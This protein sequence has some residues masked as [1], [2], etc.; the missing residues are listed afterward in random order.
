MLLYRKAVCRKCRGGPGITGL[1]D[2]VLL[3]YER[4]TDQ[5]DA[6]QKRRA[7]YGQGYYEKYAGSNVS[8]SDGMINADCCPFLARVM[9]KDLIIRKGNG[10]DT[11]WAGKYVPPGAY[12]IVEVKAGKG[13][14]AGWGRLKSGA[15]WIVLSYAAKRV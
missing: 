11:A 10:T 4:P 8:S 7:G 2:A 5:S 6:V 14:N 13:S 15:G 1:G 9:A 3:W 12:M